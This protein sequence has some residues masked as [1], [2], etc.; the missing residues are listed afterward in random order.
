MAAER[1]RCLAAGI[2]LCLTKPVV[3]ADL[4]AALASVADRS[5]PVTD[6]LA[7]QPA[8]LPTLEHGLSDVPVLDLALLQG[9]AQNLPESAFHGLLRR[10]LAG[11]GESCLRLRA[12]LAD[13]DLLAK[14]AHRL[15]G[16]S[17]TFGFARV[18]AIA[19]LL[20]ER[21][22]HGGDSSGLMADLEIALEATEQAIRTM[23]V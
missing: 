7:Q 22:A 13:P 4:F 11:A 2:N 18:S 10:G 9:L 1:E 8:V 23:D 17:G 14:E 5:A 16:T 6:E 19:G 15:R 3:W 21:I 20:E 12:A